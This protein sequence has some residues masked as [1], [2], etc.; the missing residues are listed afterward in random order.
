MELP[1]AADCAKTPAAIKKNKKPKRAGFINHSFFSPPGLARQ[2]ANSDPRSPESSGTEER[3]V[4]KIGTN[5][6]Q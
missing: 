1:G 5:T 2:T 6:I 3:P 4:K